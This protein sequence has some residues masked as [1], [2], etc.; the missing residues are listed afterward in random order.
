MNNKILKIAIISNIVLQPYL[1]SLIKCAFEQVS[2][3]T[4]VDFINYE[5]IECK[6]SDD[7]LKTTNIVVT[8]LNFDAM[9][10]NCSNEILIGKLTD[11]DIINNYISNVMKVTERLAQSSSYNLLILPENYYENTKNVI[12]YTYKQSLL[13]DKLNLKIATEIL[14]NVDLIDL[15]YIIAEIGI[16]NAYDFKNK[17]RW[18]MPYSKNLQR[19]LADAIY[20]R[21]SCYISNSKKCLILD[22]DNV[23]WGGILLEDGFEGIKIGQNGLGH[24]YNDF[25]KFVLYLYYHGIIIVVCSKND[26]TDIEYVFDD[27]SGMVLRQEHVACVKANWNNKS[28]NII[29][30][31]DILNIDRQS[32]VFVDDSQNEI[33]EIKACLPEVSTICFNPATIYKELSIFNLGI[34]DVVQSKMRTDAYRTKH[35]RDEVEKNCTSFAEYERE[36]CIDMEIKPADPTEYMRISELSQRTNKC[37]NGKRYTVEEIKARVKEENVSLYSVYLSDR[38]SDFGLVGALEIESNC[39]E[40]FTLSCRAMGK[41]IEQKMLDFVF[42]KHKINDIF[43]KETMKND[44]IYELIKRYLTS[45]DRK[46][47][48]N[49]N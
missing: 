19:K 43:F 44:S 35:L 13:I 1:E 4:V 36:M 12:G 25:Q 46:N 26:I 40:L 30:I 21:Y 20:K 8:L 49:R 39:L 3:D 48:S 47:S 34:A 10:P 5:E 23:L 28:K 29:E 27:H 16:E 17:Y 2:L 14:A 31:S 6:L 15:K 11:D 22:C 41:N 37:T 7:Y 24:A 32:M 18:N 38:F 33:S 45:N 42:S 9:Y